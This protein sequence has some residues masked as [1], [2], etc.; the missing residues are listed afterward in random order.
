[1]VAD[2]EFKLV[3]ALGY[4]EDCLGQG[5]E[6]NSQVT[7]ATYA[8]M[9]PNASLVYPSKKRLIDTR[10]TLVYQTISQ[11][12]HKCLLDRVLSLSSP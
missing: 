8:L 4:V 6:N 11:I 7:L 1:M 12:G 3:T 5:N 10:Q 2:C 9:A